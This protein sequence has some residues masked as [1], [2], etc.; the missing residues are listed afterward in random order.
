VSKA[1]DKD[2]KGAADDERDDVGG[3]T[4]S[5]TGDVT[6]DRE[7]LEEAGS[8]MHI[9]KEDSAD[10]RRSPDDE[11]VGDV[12][13]DPKALEEADEKMRIEHR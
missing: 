10:A 5:P 8:R 4:E 6:Y 11:E 2:Q 9:D 12:K 13:H 3:I 1:N 7:A